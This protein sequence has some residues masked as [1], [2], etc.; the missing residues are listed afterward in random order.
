M[1]DSS[2]SPLSSLPHAYRWILAAGYCDDAASYTVSR[3]LDF[4]LYP[5]S[6]VR[7][8]S[9]ASEL[10]YCRYV[11]Y[12]LRGQEPLPTHMFDMPLWILI[13]KLPLHEDF[14]SI[15]RHR[16]PPGGFSHGYQANDMRRSIARHFKI[17]TLLGS[18][19]PNVHNLCRF[20]NSSPIMNTEWDILMPLSCLKVRRCWGRCK[21]EERCRDIPFTPPPNSPLHEICSEASISNPHNAAGASEYL[22]QPTTIAPYYL[23]HQRKSE[24]SFLTPTAKFSADS[25]HEV[26]ASGSRYLNLSSPNQTLIPFALTSQL[27]ESLKSFPFSYA[28]CSTVRYPIS[29]HMIH[30]YRTPLPSPLPTHN[31]IF[32]ILTHSEHCPTVHNLS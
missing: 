24:T 4:E 26:F 23:L 6:R 22:S 9:L 13:M 25:R 14:S 1:L 10:M 30:Y 28:R 5:I 20:W 19:K 29:L 12:I 7:H 15:F 18:Q 17:P 11:R 8:N 27:Y 2:L 32:L 21:Q 31:N 16:S 3:T